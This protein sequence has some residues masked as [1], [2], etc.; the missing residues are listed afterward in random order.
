MGSINA[1]WAVAPF[2]EISLVQHAFGFSLARCLLFGNSQ[3]AACPGHGKQYVHDFLSSPCGSCLF[4]NGD[5]PAWEESAFVRMSGLPCF[6]KLLSSATVLEAGGERG[7][8]VDQKVFTQ[9]FASL[10]SW[11]F[12]SSDFHEGSCSPRFTGGGVKMGVWF[13]IIQ[14]RTR[15][16]HG[17]LYWLLGCSSGFMRWPIIAQIYFWATYELNFV[18]LMK[19]SPEIKTLF[20]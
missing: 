20:F 8:G 3:F 17:W 9:P 7:G 5:S 19:F 11:S 13:W 6:S 14:R 12:F 4:G 18:S 16:P 2:Q 1:I 15:L 10:S